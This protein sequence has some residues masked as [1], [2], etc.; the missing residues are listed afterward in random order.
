MTAA[1]VEADAEE[2][3][4]EVWTCLVCGQPN[5]LI[6]AGRVQTHFRLLPW[7]TDC[8]GSRLT[9]GEQVR[10]AMDRPDGAP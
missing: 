1:S 6:I 7:A 9:P 4:P 8:P 3:T 5:R 2:G 10:V